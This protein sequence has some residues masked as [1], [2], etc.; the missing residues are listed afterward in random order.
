MNLTI[1]GETV[2]NIKA[3]TV[4][5]L[6]GELKIV[7]GRVAVEVN[8]SVIKKAEHETYRLKDGDIVEIVSFVGGG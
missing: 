5:E 3:G 2:D 6:L 4:S 8:L 7:P 1:N